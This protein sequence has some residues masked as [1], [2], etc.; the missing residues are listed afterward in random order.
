VSKGLS[1][2]GEVPVGLIASD[3]GGTSLTSWTPPDALVGCSITSNCSNWRDPTTGNP[4]PGGDHWNAMVYPFTVGPMALSGFAWYQ[5]ENGAGG[6][7][8]DIQPTQPNPLYQNDSD[9]ELYACLFAPMI[10]SWRKA[11][12]NPDAYFGFIQIS[13]WEDMKHGDSFTPSK[14]LHPGRS[15]T[16]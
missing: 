10:S 13:S 16:A 6:L 3:W 9:I 7:P 11:F 1:L 15:R 4:W 5:G 12:K 8:C 2:T 14:D